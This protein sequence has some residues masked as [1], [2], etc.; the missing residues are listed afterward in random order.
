MACAHIHTHI[1]TH[2]HIHCRDRGL[3]LEVHTREG[4]P[5]KMSD[6]RKVRVAADC[7]NL[8]STNHSCRAAQ[9]RWH[10]LAASGHRLLG[11]AYTRVLPEVMS[12][13][14]PACKQLTCHACRC[15][16]QVAASKASTIIVLH[17]ENTSSANAEA[18]K[19]S[20][21]MSLTA[22][23]ATGQQRVVVQ[24]TLTSTKQTPSSHYSDHHVE[25][26]APGGAAPTCFEPFCYASCRAICWHQHSAVVFGGNNACS[27][28]T[29]HDTGV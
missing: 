23:G 22:L 17:P 24:G 18:I 21:A 3:K 2:T 20:V 29:L 8:Y 14:V 4:N 5:F 9:S 13:Q 28:R 26:V 6:L 25:L 11:C 27:G 1:L 16:D 15:L 10:L 7:H 12:L 19:V